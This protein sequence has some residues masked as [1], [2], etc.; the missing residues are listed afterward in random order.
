M[1]SEL[2]VLLLPPAH[3]WPAADAYAVVDALRATTTAVLLLH[4]GARA[5]I[6]AES[7]AGARAVAQERGALLAGEV[8]GLP[9][10]GFDMGNSPA[11][12]GSH[13]VAG[14]EVVLFTT[15]GTLALCAAAARGP[16][17]AACALNAAAAAR[18]LAE[19]H[20]VAIVCAGEEHGTVFALEDLAAA[21]CIVRAL[22]AARPDLEL[23]DGA[24]LALMLPDPVTAIGA[25]AHA[26]ALRALGLGEDI[27]AA[28]AVDTVQLVPVVTALGA[29]WVR[30][31]PVRA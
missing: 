2:D 10:P 19:R 14:R 3:Q 28:Q 11:E 24:R 5:V 17:A 12:V 29:G 23:G 26:D 7:E 22:V 6:A 1:V 30:L 8:G 18:W 13:A 9:P 21:A 4:H 20:R 25:S 16:A 31:E 27:A 15:N